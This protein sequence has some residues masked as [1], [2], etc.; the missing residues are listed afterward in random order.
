M[1]KKIIEMALDETSKTKILIETTEEV[2]PQ[3]VGAGMGAGAA[4]IADQIVNNVV[5]VADSTFKGVMGI[6][7]YSSNVLLAEIDKIESKPDSAQIEF[8]VK[9]NGE[10]KA[11]L[12]SVGA[13]TNYK[14]TLSW[15]KS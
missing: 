15:K 1:P 8:G 10:G 6:I 11:V 2:A 4:G 7:S 14:I 9:L 12:A 13:E 3:Q 5:N